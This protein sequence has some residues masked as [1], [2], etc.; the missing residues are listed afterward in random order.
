M[1]CRFS[2]IMRAATILAVAACGIF[3]PSAHAAVNSYTITI[4]TSRLIGRSG[5]PFSVAFYLSDGSGTGD[6]NNTATLS[7]FDFGGGSA[8]GA[9]TQIGGVSGS[10]SSGIVLTDSLYLNWLIQPFNPGSHLMFSVSATN[11]IDAGPTPDL[12]AV[13][14]LDGTGQPIMTQTRQPFFYPFATITFNSPNP[15]VQNYAPV[16]ALFA[17]ATS[18]GSL[19]QIAS[20]GGWQT[21]FDLINTGTG[22][23]TARLNFFSDPSGTPLP[24]PLTFPQVALTSTTASTIDRTINPNAVLAMDSTGSISASEQSGWSQLLTTGNISGFG[25]FSNTTYNWNAVV[26]LETRNASSYIL[27]FDNTGVLATGVAVANLATQ[28]ANVPVVIRDDTG[29]S[30]GT[31]QIALAAQGHTSFMLN[32]QY[33]ATTGKRGTIEFDTPPGGQISALGLRANGPALTTLPVLGNV[34]SPGGSIAHVTYN[35]GFTSTF[36]L[37][38]TG[39]SSAAFT[40]SFF[41]ES[42]N[43][44][45]V[46]LSLP[47]TGATQSTAALAQTLAAGAMLE[48]DTQAQD[49]L[50][51]VAGSAQLTT[52]GNVS[53]FEVFRW[54]TY[55]QEASV[56]LETRT[57]NSFVLIYDNAGGLTTGLALANVATQA[58]SVT[59]NLRDDT[60]ALLLNTSINVPGRG[61]T[62]FMLPDNYSIAAGK[63]GTVEFVTPAGGRISVIGIRATPTG[64]LTTIPVLTK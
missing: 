7:G 2:L 17:A 9:S 33:S 22:T 38:N 26:P 59:V 46:P 25:I 50:A 32:Q 14:I 64:T 34:D 48:V 3:A 6:G 10:L 15:G 24:L 16:S 13:S 18:A 44:Q 54:T 53:G 8:Q 43:A 31:A 62:A 55:G 21:S 27:A 28:A 52:T 63:H 4:D 56:P 58:A 42:G 40:L 19:A 23:G 5:G 45:Q 35:G 51:G 39:T 1:N 37:V 49:A 12:F 60:G 61:H 20:A 57:P 11:N 47:Q 36:Y 30:I 29:A 41:D